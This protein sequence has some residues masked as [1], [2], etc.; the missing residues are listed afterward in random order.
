MHCY[1]DN[2]C[3]TILKNQADAMAADSRLL[4]T[5]KI[6]E[7]IPPVEVATIDFY[8]LCLGGKERT[9]EGFDMIASRAGLKIIGVHGG[10][11]MPISV[12]ECMKA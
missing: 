2:D 1:S 8:M 6:I 5:E 12:I 11:G 10:R 9:I 3:V 7:S 4:I